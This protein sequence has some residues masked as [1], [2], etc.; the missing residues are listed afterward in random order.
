MEK[1][2]DLFFDPS[3]QDQPRAESTKLSQLLWFVAPHI[4]QQL[5]D[6]VFQQGAGSYPCIWRRTPFACAF[7]LTA[8]GELRHF[9]FQQCRDATVTRDGKSVGTRPS[10]RHHKNLKR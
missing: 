5:G 1:D 4:A 9:L 7:E 10:S 3:L 2:G 8:I 6:L